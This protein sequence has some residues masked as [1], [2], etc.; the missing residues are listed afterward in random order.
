MSKTH[1]EAP[2]KRDRER[3]E[4]PRHAR[5]SPCHDCGVPFTADD[6][7]DDQDGKF[8]F[9]GGCVKWR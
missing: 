5:K 1:R 3:E 8:R 2:A 6:L 7:Y 9:C 4:K